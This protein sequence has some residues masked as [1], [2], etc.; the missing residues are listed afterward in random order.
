MK[1]ST[2]IQKQHLFSD[3]RDLEKYISKLR[4]VSKKQESLFYIHRI[5]ELPRWTNKIYKSQG[6][7]QNL[8]ELKCNCAEHKKLSRKYSN[9]DIR[10]VCRHLYWKLTTTKVKDEIDEL[11]K[12]L[13]VSF[14]KNKERNLFRTSLKDEPLVL[15]LS[16]PVEWI[17]I[18]VGEK[19]WKRF[20]FNVPEK[21]W[22]YN[23]SPQN[24]KII[25]TKIYSILEYLFSES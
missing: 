12:I 3:L 7:K 1:N 16:T 24:M 2:S 19:K 18:F 22:A 25:E 11:T 13:L 10:L 8:Y 14:N 17:D 4:L 5:P 23:E 21:R 20:S 15:G 9:R 6:Y